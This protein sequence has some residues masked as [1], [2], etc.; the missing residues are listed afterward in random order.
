MKIIKLL[1]LFV[2]IF[3]LIS[4]ILFAYY[5]FDFQ[6]QDELDYYYEIGLIDANEYEEYSLLFDYFPETE[7]E[8]EKEITDKIEIKKDKKSIKKNF[9]Q[10]YNFSYEITDYKEKSDDYLSIFKLENEFFLFK[11]DYKKSLKFGVL[12]LNKNFISN[13]FVENEKKFYNSDSYK[14]NE[15]EKV[16]IDLNLQDTHIIIGDFKARFGMGLT[17]SKTNSKKEGLSQDL[18]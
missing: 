1:L 2:N 17:F 6:N 10:R 18:S 12:G 11:D 15:M 7:D 13:T 8:L 16:Y 3:L 4:D 9:I 14:K 5:D